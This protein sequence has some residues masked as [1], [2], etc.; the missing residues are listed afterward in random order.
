MQKPQAK[1]LPG[2]VALRMR[3]KAIVSSSSRLSLSL[4]DPVGDVRC[5]SR[6]NNPLAL[7]HGR[8]LFGTDLP[9][10]RFEPTAPSQKDLRL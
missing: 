8:R 5:L 1:T 6:F 4:H 7:F 10:R 9:S 3:S 2:A